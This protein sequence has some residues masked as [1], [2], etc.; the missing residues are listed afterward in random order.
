DR[1]FPTIYSDLE[2]Y[3]RHQATIHTD[4]WYGASQT[5]DEQTGHHDTGQPPSVL[6]RDPTAAADFTHLAGLSLEQI[7]ELYVAG[8]TAP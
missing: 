1:K 2:F 3:T 8:P 5:S 7:R 6:F 4:G